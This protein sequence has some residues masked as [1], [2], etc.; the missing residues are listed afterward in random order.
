MRSVAGV[1][2]FMLLAA[3]LSGSTR[4]SIAVA[5]TPSKAT[6][7][8]ALVEAYN[9]SK[10][11]WLDAATLR[12]LAKRAVA[13]PG[14]AW[15]PVFSPA[16]RYVAFGGPGA[17]GV[18]IVDLQRMKLVASVA[19]RPWHR[20][21]TPLAWPERRR[22]LVLDS[23]QDAQGAPDALLA[24]DPFQRRILG[25]TVRASSARTWRSWVP[26]GHELLVL[27]QRTEEMG[28]LR[29][30]VFGPNA[31]ILRAKDVGIVGGVFPEHG[32]AG[33]PQA[34]VASPALAGDP[35]GR[36]AFVVDSLTIASVDLKTLDVS[37]ARLAEPRSLAARF[38]AWL[39]PAA[40]A[41]LA[42][43][44]SR[45]ATWLGDGLLAV[46]GATFEGAW[47]TPSGLQLVDTQTGALRTLEPRA[48]AH[49]FSQGLLL[50][51]GASRDR[52]T[53][54]ENGMG[55]AAF[56]R[57]GVRVWSALGD[58][59]VW[60]AETAAGYAYVPTPEET[61]PPGIRVIDLATGAVVR[62][63]RGEMPT[64]VVRD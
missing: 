56:S 20:R 14:G 41:K 30:V 22:L 34:R 6:E 54:V 13:L 1:F 4:E 32:D 47:S 2:A 49:R 59:R 58:E 12:P 52:A 62:T 18:R 40:Q 19:K 25:R 21:L 7:V 43:G 38:F 9:G 42:S 55:L 29:L 24:V 44:F 27:S 17:I 11:V 51:F 36:R 57:E 26:V 33:A 37:Y 45:Q 39:E 10:L 64:F 3:G 46:S 35:Y 63:V 5:Q 48:S 8:L 15:G 53:N 31:G 50:A 16:G 61:F 23:P 60:L 28:V